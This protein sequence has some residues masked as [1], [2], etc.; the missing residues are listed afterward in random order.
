MYLPSLDRFDAAAALAALGLLVFGYLVYP[1]HLV[2]VTVWLSIF[3]ISVGWLAFFLWK[4]MYDV[5]L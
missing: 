5:D 1:T 3:T 4:W 2:Q